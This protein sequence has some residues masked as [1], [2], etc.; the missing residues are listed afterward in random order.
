MSKINNVKVKRIFPIGAEV[1]GTKLVSFRVWA[2]IRKKVSVIL[3]VEKGNNFET[4]FSAELQKEPDGYF[5]VEVE[6]K[7]GMLYRFLLDDG[8]Q[9]FPDPASRFQPYG[10]HGPSQIV[11]SN[12]FNW[13]DND[14]KGNQ[15]KGQII[16]EMHLGTF[17]P[18][19]NLSSAAKQLPELAKLGITTIELMPI[20]DFPVNS[21]GD[22]MELTFLLHPI[23]MDYLMI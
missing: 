15:L 7:A 18:E 11:N 5:Q 21:A 1:I 22:T 2:P 10:P 13:S 23:Y 17:T 9:L 3:E 8:Q 19:G 16:Y 12:N 20:A 14:W 6:A 4:V